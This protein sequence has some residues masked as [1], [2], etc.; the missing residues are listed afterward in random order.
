MA[1]GV[2]DEKV[3]IQTLVSKFTKSDKRMYS[4]ETNSSKAPLNLLTRET[5]VQF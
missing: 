1:T 4:Q 3:F 2:G 5:G